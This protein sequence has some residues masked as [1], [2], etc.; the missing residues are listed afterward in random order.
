MK[1][2]F[3]QIS[4]YIN[5]DQSDEIVVLSDVLSEQEAFGL[6]VLDECVRKTFRRDERFYEAR[7]F[8]NET[9]SSYGMFNDDGGNYVTYLNG[10]LQKYLPGVAAATY[11]AVQLAY[12]QS[13]WGPKRNLSSPNELGVHSAEYLKYSSRGR[14]SLH[15]DD[16]SVYTISVALNRFDD[17]RGGYFRLA[18]GEALF[19]VPRRSAIVFF[20]ESYHGVTEIE[21]GERRVF[22]LELWNQPDAP[23]GSARPQKDDYFHIE[24]VPNEPS[25]TELQTQTDSVV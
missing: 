9:E 11:K 23:I 21:N 19:K 20:G 3:A 22:V 18:T 13:G 24:S 17:Y 1:R 12:D 5:A 16:E 10:L 6:E 7:E 25:C 2:K 8:G 4:K 14:L 15:V